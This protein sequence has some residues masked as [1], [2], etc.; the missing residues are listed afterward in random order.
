MCTDCDVWQ[1]SR[2]ITF[3]SIFVPV[4]LLQKNTN[5]NLHTCKD[6]SWNIFYECKFTTNKTAKALL[7]CFFFLFR[8]PKSVKTERDVRIQRGSLIVS[9]VDDVRKEERFKSERFNT[10][11]AVANLRHGLDECSSLLSLGNLPMWRIR[12]LTYRRVIA[13]QLWSV[14]SLTCLPAPLLLPLHRELLGVFNNAQR[15]KKLHLDLWVKLSFP[16]G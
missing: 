7:F 1:V 10:I 11:W 15:K 13:Q 16:F 5:V 12:D 6:T 8:V 4:S 14:T 3:A 9:L 2:I